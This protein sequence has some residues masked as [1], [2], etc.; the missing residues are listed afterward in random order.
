MLNSALFTNATTICKPFSP[1]YFVPVS[2]AGVLFWAL[3]NIYR[4]RSNRNVRI[5]LFKPKQTKIFG[6][7]KIEMSKKY[8]LI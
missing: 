7:R 1:M 2:I 5:D 3:E 6:E 4:V 8:L